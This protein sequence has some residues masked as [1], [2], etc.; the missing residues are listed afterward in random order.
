MNLITKEIEKKIPALYSTDGQK[1]DRPVV[2]KFFTPDSNWSWMV[3]EGEK[4]ENGDW[5]FFGLVEGFETELG[6]FSLNELKAAKG[7]LGLPVERDLYLGN[8][9]LQEV[10]PEFCERLWGDK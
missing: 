8:K 9:T 2:C 7:P 10:A 5:Y 4:Q 6:Y 3:L 1:G